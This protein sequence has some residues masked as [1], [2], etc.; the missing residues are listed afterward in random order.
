[1]KQLTSAV[2]FGS[3]VVSFCAAEMGRSKLQL[4]GTRRK[5]LSKHKLHERQTVRGTLTGCR[6]CNDFYALNP[7]TCRE[8]KQKI[9]LNYL[10][11]LL[12]YQTNLT[13]EG[14]K[15]HSPYYVIYIVSVHAFESLCWKAHSNNVWVDI[16]SVRVKGKKKKTTHRTQHHKI[17]RRFLKRKTSGGPS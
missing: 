1:M 7:K 17:L 5:F 3:I 11:M 14:A 4:A 6:F 12:I 15:H 13:K 16:C 10:K 2:K 8:G 9:I